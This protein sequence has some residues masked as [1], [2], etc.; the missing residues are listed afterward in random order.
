MID[1]T[2]AI[3]Y[4]YHTSIFTCYPFILLPQ[5]KLQFFLQI[6]KDSQKERVRYLLA[7]TTNNSNLCLKISNALLHFT[8][9]WKPMITVIDEMNDLFK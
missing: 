3:Y 2:N 8:A 4:Y 7:A 6:L 1:T 9:D 5:Q